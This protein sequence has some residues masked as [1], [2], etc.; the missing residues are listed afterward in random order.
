MQAD[1]QSA[2]R[3]L[4]QTP[5]LTAVAFV[6]LAVA[7]GITTAA[8][9]VVYGAFLSPLPVPGGDR[10]V[11]IHEYHR[12]GRFNVPL[13]ARQFTSRRHQT[14]TFEAVGAW[15]SRNITLTSDRAGDSASGLVRAAHVSPESLTIVGVPA[16]LG[17]HPAASDVTPGAPAVVVLGHDVWRARFGADPD[18]LRRAVY[19]AGRPHQVIGVMPPRFAFPIRDHVWI[20]VQMNA[21][22]AN[23]TPED[24]TLFGK[25][26]PGVSLRE[27][28][29]ELAVLGATEQT[30]DAKD[31]TS[32]LV[33]PFTRGFM[34][35]EQEWAIYGFLIGVMAFLI[36]IAANLANLFFA[37]NSARAREMALRSALG[38]SRR[39]LMTQLLVE[40]LVLAT[41]AA[42]AG[43][44]VSRVAIE[45]F[46]Q[47]V[48]DLPWWA[49]FGIN[50][51][52]LGFVACS[53][54]LATVVAGLGP[55]ARLTR[56]APAEQLKAGGGTF[57][58]RFSP[59]GA[60]LIVVQVAISVAFL[61]VVSVLAQGLFGF[62]YQRYQL[63]G[64]SVLVAQVYLGAPDATELSR[65]GAIRTDVWKRH[66]ARSFEQFERIRE[67][68]VRLRGVRHVTLSSHFPGNDVEAVRI[69]LDPAVAGPVE[70]VTTRIAA[71]G[72]D[73]FATLAARVELGRD[74]SAAERRGPPTAVIVNAPFAR[75]YFAGQ[76]PLGRSLR[77]LSTGGA[78]AGPWLEIVGVVPDL[79]LNP[80]DPTRADGIYLPFEGSN[81]ARLALNTDGE[82]LSLVPLV[83]GVVMR[84]NAR[85]QVQAVQT[86]GAQMDAAENVFRGLGAG[87]LVIGGTALLLSAVSFYSLVSFGVTRR[88]RE[89]GIRLA[90]GAPPGRILRGVLAGELKM[91]CVGAVG[92]VLLG[93]GLYQLVA[94]L[95]FDLRP[96]GPSLAAA[97]AGLLLVVGAGACLM[98]ARRALSITPID[99]LKDE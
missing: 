5:G 38:A 37:R 67:A 36:V 79:A 12:S 66:S 92:G 76:S 57:T 87:L 69:Q 23:S 99:A 84:E 43:L 6:S 20:P 89:I 56:I 25:L 44:M 10:L 24:V 11:T 58:L 74:F 39:R 70:G 73:F 16:L 61:S 90:L 62:S 7:I 35:P 4:R 21:D 59:V 13:T 29:A 46:Q 18:I 17:R 65:P 50:A 14:T 52:V 31:A 47:Q 34:T 86:L 95:P 9:S 8:F 54:L 78:G 33:M 91:V 96:A 22:A 49:D 85:A 19:V 72:A 51:T 55:A 88:T 71:V 97:F 68:L 40:S 64:E 27:A 93:L 42:V 2:W 41:T 45:W 94:Q 81:F 1:V 75:K 77:L 63:P 30:R 26:R 98:P 3:T 53:A 80:G 15:Y 48:E 83:H 82:P 32:P 60:A 28:S